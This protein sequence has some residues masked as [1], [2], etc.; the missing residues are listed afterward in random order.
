VG[1]V[2]GGAIGGLVTE[3]APSWQPAVIWT[4]LA[5]VIISVAGCRR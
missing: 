1:I 3:R 5:A 4:P 2:A